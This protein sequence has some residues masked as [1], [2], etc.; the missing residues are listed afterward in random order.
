MI[1]PVLLLPDKIQK[2]ASTSV[3]KHSKLWF[4][5][6]EEKRA[7][8]CLGFAQAPIYLCV[9]AEIRLPALPLVA[10]GLS[11]KL[12]LNDTLGTGMALLE[13]DNKQSKNSA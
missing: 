8:W 12:F 4:V 5:P 2:S 9:L 1:C 11:E 6:A 3:L 13:A 10:S 7:C